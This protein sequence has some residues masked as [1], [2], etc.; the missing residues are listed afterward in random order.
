MLSLASVSFSRLPVSR[1]RCLYS[2][3]LRCQSVSSSEFSTCLEARRGAAPRLSARSSSRSR[4]CCRNSFCRCFLRCCS[5]GS[6]AAPGAA[7]CSS[8]SSLPG[9]TAPPSASPR[10]R[11]AARSASTLALSLSA[12][13]LS[14]SPFCRFSFSST[15]LRAVRR[16]CS[17]S[18]PSRMRCAS[19][20]SSRS[21]RASSMASCALLMRA[22]PARPVSSASSSAASSPNDSRFRSFFPFLFLGF[23]AVCALAIRSS[24]VVRGTMSSNGFHSTST[25]VMTG[26]STG[27]SFSSTSS[28]PIRTTL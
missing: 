7:S 22:C 24:I 4:S 19:A 23:F 18:S 1:L 17:S 14:S 25:S 13:P 28:S 16:A 26:G 8:A 9:G 2:A 3:R 10:S 5:L 27:L 20:S 15:L 6:S 11:L 21:R 12:S